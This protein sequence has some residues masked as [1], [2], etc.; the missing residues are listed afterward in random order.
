MRQI[1]VIQVLEEDGILHLIAEF[2]VFEAA[3][4][5]KWADARPSISHNFL[6]SVLHIPVKFVSDFLGNV[7]SHLYLQIRRSAGR[8]CDTFSGRSG[9]SITPF[10]SIRNSGMTLFDIV[11]NKYLIVVQLN[12][13]FNGIVLGVDLREVQDSFQ[14]ERIVHIQMDP[15]QWF[16]VIQEYFA[17][18]LADS[19]LRCTRLDVLPTA[20]ECHLIGTGRFSILTFSLAGADFYHF[21]FAVFIFLLFHLGFFM[22]VLY[23]DIDP[24][25]DL[26]SSMVSYSGSVHWPFR[27]ENLYRHE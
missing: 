15:E 6:R 24:L 13:S 8:F 5:D 21:F 19:L 10:K 18:K 27:E 14:V 7:V 2:L 20:G 12:C 9:Q 4:F 22:D 1:L 17:V 25:S 11:R 3:E 26:L 23:D 16:F